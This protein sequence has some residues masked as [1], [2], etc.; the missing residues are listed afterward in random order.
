M[1]DADESVW[2]CPYFTF[3][4]DT[5]LT[6]T[7]VVG[8]HHLEAQAA[9]VY[10]ATRAKY[11]S[12]LGNPPTMDEMLVG[13]STA[14]RVL[15]SIFMDEQQPHRVEVVSAS[16]HPNDGLYPGGRGTHNVGDAVYIETVTVAPTLTEANRVV[17]SVADRVGGMVQTV[18]ENVPGYDRR[19]WLSAWGASH[20]NVRSV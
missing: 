4:T 12:S 11:A 7:L 6:A 1:P 10:Y 5:E 20:T 15:A 17:A 19:P 14:A 2:E 16:L 18:G 13:G 9:G 8:T 3:T